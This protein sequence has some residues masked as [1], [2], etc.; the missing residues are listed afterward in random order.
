MF[1]Y[2]YLK[3][4]D[5]ERDFINVSSSGGA[6]LKKEDLTK[7]FKEPLLSQNPEKH[8][9]LIREPFNHTYNCAKNLKLEDHKHVIGM[10]EDGFEKVL[11]KGNFII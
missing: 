10:F 1:F 9:F 2:Y 5:A 4:F 7:Y 6:L 8:Y 11:T 3:K